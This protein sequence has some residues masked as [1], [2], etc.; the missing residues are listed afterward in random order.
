MVIEEKDL[1]EILK[2]AEKNHGPKA[3]YYLAATIIWLE[4]QLEQS[5]SAGYIRRKAKNKKN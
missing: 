3:A 5:T 4:K 2:K 1:I